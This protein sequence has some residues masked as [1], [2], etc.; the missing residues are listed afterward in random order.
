MLY[1][2]LRF[3]FDDLCE[4]WKQNTGVGLKVSN[5]TLAPIQEENKIMKQEECRAKKDY[6]QATEEKELHRN[7]L[8]KQ[9]FKT[10]A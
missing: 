5:L 4:L 8:I 1:G 6:K 9:E 3:V 10:N 7:G 2:K